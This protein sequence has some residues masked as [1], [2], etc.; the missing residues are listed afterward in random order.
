MD[1]VSAIGLAGNIFQFIDFAAKLFSE[2]QNIYESVTGL[3]DE[4][5]ELK[6]IAHRLESITAV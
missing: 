3:P 1:P 2:A 4:H 6:I 5:Q